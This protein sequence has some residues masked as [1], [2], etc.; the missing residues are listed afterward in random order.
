MNNFQPMRERVSGLLIGSLG[1][2]SACGG[3]GGGGSS[4]AST[5]TPVA[6][7]AVGGI[8]TGP[9]PTTGLQ[10]LGIVSEAGELYF[11]RADGASYFG[12]VASSGNNVSGSFQGVTAAG[13]IFPD[14]S[15][16][17]NG[18]ISGTISARSSLNATYSFT[19]AFGTKTSAT[20]T[21]NF[22]S[23]YNIASSLASI[24]GTYADN[25]DG[26]VISINSDGSVFAQN[27]YSG[28]VTNGQV[29]IINANYNAYSVS[30][31]ESNCVG[32]SAYLN[33]QTGNGLAALDTT[34]SPY[35][36]YFGVVDTGT[37]PPV[38]VYRDLIRQ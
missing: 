2:L 27:P 9:D 5:P 30:I 11:Y 13:Y 34:I 21:L 24:A 38:S 4:T 18:T 25:L 3:G 16:Y 6:N 23:L 15:S 17:G 26:E 28:C 14:G 8:W 32:G 1:F 29:S 36:L 31:T 22:S 10:V 20:G 35:H 7:V 12:S 19:T 37:S 33:G